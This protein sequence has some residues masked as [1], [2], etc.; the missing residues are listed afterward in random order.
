MTRDENL[1]HFDA[2]DWLLKTQCSFCGRVVPMPHAFVD[3]WFPA[4][5]TPG[6]PCG[7]TLEACPECAEKHC[8]WPDDGDTTIKPGHERFVKSTRAAL[9]S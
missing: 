4:I 7:S 5:C 9:N 8:H 3:G 2:A 6:N 1:A